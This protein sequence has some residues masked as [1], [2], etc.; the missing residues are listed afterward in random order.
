M[1]HV[2]TVPQTNVVSLPEPPAKRRRRMLLVGAG[3]VVGLIVAL[4]LVL[5]YSPLLAVKNIEVQGIEL[6][7]EAAVREALEPL[8][9]TPLP[10][11]GP[12]SVQRLLEGQPAVK[13]VVVQAE[14]PSTLR[15]EV[16]EY[17][18]VAIVESK[19]KF[20]L[21]AEDG[22]AL[23]P[24]AKRDGADLP[25]IDA[26]VSA[27]DPKVFATVTKVLASLPESVLNRMDKAGAKTIDSVELRLVNGQTVL[28]GNAERNADKARVVEALLKTKNEPDAAAV[29]VYDVTSPDHPVTR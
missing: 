11:I 19:G 13:D 24:L 29:K 1:S 2:D 27:A 20:R 3:S 21:V 16:I 12:A 25:V 8:V 9:G 5:L 22:R 18:P 26:G 10:G 4:I 28:W 17:A 23:A 6:A 7:R 15:V 14:A